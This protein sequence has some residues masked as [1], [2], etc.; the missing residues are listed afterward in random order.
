MS[1]KSRKTDRNGDLPELG[2]PP[3]LMD[4][5]VKGP[6]SAE[7]VQSLCLSFKKALIERAMG[8]QVNLAGEKEEYEVA[9]AESFTG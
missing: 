6:M 9:E 1:S 2:I 5:M 8:K 3:E 4:Q 7:E